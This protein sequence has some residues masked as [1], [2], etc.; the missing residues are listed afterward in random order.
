MYNIY[1]SNRNNS[2]FSVSCQKLK[3][4]VV[5]YLQCCKTKEKN[6]SFSYLVLLLDENDIPYGA[7]Y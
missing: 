1:K 3:K 7:I 5:D 6:F 2:V 4:M